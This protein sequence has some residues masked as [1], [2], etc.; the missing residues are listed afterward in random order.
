MVYA[1]IKDSI[2]RNVIVLDDVTLA[3][4][5]D[6]SFDAIVRID[7][8]FPSPGIGWSYDGNTFS[9]PLEEES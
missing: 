7:N 1:Q 6:D 4:L 8:L 3:P 9:P 5:F 2:V